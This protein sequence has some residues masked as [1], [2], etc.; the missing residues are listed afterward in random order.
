MPSPS[1][2][3]F[4]LQLAGHH[5][6]SMGVLGLAGVYATIIVAS[7]ADLQGAHALVGDLTV[8]GV[9]TDGNLVLHPH[10]LGLEDGE[11]IAIFIL[12]QRKV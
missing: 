1:I 5:C 3:T 2:L 11:E 6:L 8:L 10:D 9:F 7:L 12:R 4:D